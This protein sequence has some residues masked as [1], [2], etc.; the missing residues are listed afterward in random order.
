MCCP[1]FRECRPA[2]FP[3][4]KE[5]FMTK[6]TPTPAA[7]APAPEIAPAADVPAAP[8]AAELTVHDSVDA[9][10]AVAST[11]EQPILAINSDGTVHAA[12]LQ[13]ERLSVSADAAREHHGEAIAARVLIAFDGHAPNDVIE[14]SGDELHARR[15]QVD[16]SPAAVEYARSLL[17]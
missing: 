10:G 4:T 3:K 11:G 6:R 13:V 5:K 7:A 12:A 1:R 14:L 17:A 15:G 9:V 16:P 2:A 8:I